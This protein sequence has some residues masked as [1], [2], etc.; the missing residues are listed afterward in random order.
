[1]NQKLTIPSEPCWK[2]SIFAIKTSLKF[3]SFEDFKKYLIE[4]LPQNSLKTKKQYASYILARFFPNQFLE[5]LPVMVWKSY[6]DENILLSIMRFEF[7]RR[8]KLIA[9]FIEK[10]LSGFGPGSLIPKEAFLEYLTEIIGEI[11]PKVLARFTEI[12]RSLGYLGY[13]H[14]KYFIPSIVPNKTAFLIILHHLFAKTVQTV[15]LK[16]I[17]TEPFWKYLRIP[18]GQSIK[19]ILREASAN[20]LISK[21]IVADQLE[22]ITTRYS[23]K[24]FIERKI[25]L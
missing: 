8:E 25:A 13:N 22:Q 18:N 7:L 11:R 5:Q 12:L 3:G 19:Q 2:E 23:L 1:M 9:L 20:N 24:E 14:R 10:K 21:Y 16:D 15:A 4:S 17:E 6:R